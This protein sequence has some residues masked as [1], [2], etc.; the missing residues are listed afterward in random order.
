MLVNGK[1]IKMY[2]KPDFQSSE[3]LRRVKPQDQDTSRLNTTHTVRHTR[4][5]VET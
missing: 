3:V 4:D 5:T 2:V 1:V